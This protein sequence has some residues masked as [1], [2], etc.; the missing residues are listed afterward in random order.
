LPAWSSAP[1]L[2]VSGIRWLAV[3]AIVI[4]LGAAAT[5]VPH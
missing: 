3:R 4:H 1:D 5:G 2:R